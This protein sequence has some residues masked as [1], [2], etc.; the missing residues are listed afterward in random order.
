MLAEMDQSNRWSV[1]V[2]LMSKIVDTLRTVPNVEVGL[3]V[4]G[5]NKFNELRVVLMLIIIQS[6]VIRIQLLL[7]AL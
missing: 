4:F 7:L 6:V 3:R 1:A 5:H 2:T